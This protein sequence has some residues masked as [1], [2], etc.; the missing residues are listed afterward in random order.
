MGD[1]PPKT[2]IADAIETARTAFAAFPEHWRIAS[3]A[4]ELLAADEQVSGIYLSGSFAKGKPDRWSDIDLYLIARPDSS[5]EELIRRHDKLIRDVADVAT[6]FPATHLGDPHQ[7]IAFYRASEPIHVDY[8]YRKLGWLVPRQRDSDVIILLDR[9]GDLTRWREACRTAAAE[10]STTPE[11]LQYLEV[12]FWGWCWYAHTKIERG[13]LW[14]ARDALE[15]LRSNVLVTLAHHDGQVFEGHRRLEQKLKPDVQD[16]LA[17]TIP[18]S[19]NTSSYREALDRIIDAYQ[20][21]FDRLPAAASEGVTLLDSDYFI[22]AIT[23]GRH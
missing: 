16:L 14:E 20:R 12:R 10:S 5:V 21:L 11:Q 6:L 17:S 9:H 13:E 3:R 1:R 23:K 22:E 15:Y 19:H 7:L 8:Q 18:A 4:I 2:S